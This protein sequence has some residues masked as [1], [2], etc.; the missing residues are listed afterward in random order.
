MSVSG[1]V[2]SVTAHQHN[3]YKQVLSDQLST[4]S[5]KCTPNNEQNVC[6]QSLYCCLLV[7]QVSLQSNDNKT[8]RSILQIDGTPGNGSGEK[9]LPRFSQRK[10]SV[11]KRLGKK[12]WRSFEDSSKKIQTLRGVVWFQTRIKTEANQNGFRSFICGGIIRLV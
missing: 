3:K 6:S 2:S 9:Q 10:T 5:R 8:V 7:D 11:H 12:R 1:G 4:K